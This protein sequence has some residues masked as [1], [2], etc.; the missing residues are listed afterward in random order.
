MKRALLLTT[1]SLLMAIPAYAQEADDE[2]Q[3]GEIVVTGNLSKLDV[4]V[5]ET[6]QNVTIIDE[7]AIERQ[8]ATS[9]QEIIRYVPS[10]QA[11]LTG[12]SGFDEFLIR[13]F[14]QSRYQFRDGLRLDPGYLQQQEPF[15]LA[16]VE[17]LKG[18]ASV[19]Y[20]QN[21][22]GRSGQHDQQ[23]GIERTRGECFRHNRHRRFLS[24]WSGCWRS[25]EQR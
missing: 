10:I 24:Y 21:R 4:P 25:I 3:T 5:T 13:G 9:I 23:T 18:P 6:P 15:G 1:A 16:S 12:R 2:A 7:D 19:L 11:E 14:S 8:N 20:G 17:V 22:A